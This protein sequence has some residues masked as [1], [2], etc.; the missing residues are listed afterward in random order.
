MVGEGEVFKTVEIICGD[1]IEL[2]WTPGVAKV[3]AMI[4]RT[5]VRR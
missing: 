1:G 2:G 3:I 5:G 4:C